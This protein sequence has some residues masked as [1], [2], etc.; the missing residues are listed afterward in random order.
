MSERA[1]LE[2]VAC[3]ARFDIGPL[4][5]GCRACGAKGKVA[6]LE[7]AYD[8]RAIGP[9][10]AVDNARGLWRW[11]SLLPPAGEASR[12]S[13]G[14]GRTP[15]L[16]IDCGQPGVRL[17]LKNE[18]ANP[19]W[20]WKD[21]PNCISVSMARQLG[22]H[23]TAAISTGNHGCAAAAYSAA[24]GMRCVVFCHSGAPASQLALM[25]SYGARVIR[26]GDQEALFRQ[27]LGRGDHFPCSIF[28]PRAGYASP[29]AIEGFKT[30]AFEIYE[31]LD[32]SIPDRVFVP[33]GS[34]DGIYGVWK[35][36]RELRELGW[37]DK[38]PKM[39]ACQASGADSA[40]RAFRKGSQHTE[41]L[42]SAST[43][44]LSIAERVTG[45]HALRAVYQSGGSV[46][47]CSD[48]ETLAAMRLLM[49]Q[50]LALEPASAV[51]LA[52]LQKVA[53]EWTPGETR[54]IIGSGAAVKWSTLTEGFE[55]PR[56]WGPDVVNIDEMLEPPRYV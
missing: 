10:L 25:S 17:L 42:D 50:G 35:G 23:R 21:R 38:T 5:Y 3:S 32:R 48:E 54:V 41:P 14:E 39:M 44:A 8:F 51:A 29:F 11:N 46:L 20:S 45:D 12:I 27:L 18:T 34:G 31:Q 43:I 28:C 30:I 33:V 40:Y 19:T 47:T 37:A 24:A 53:S 7:V 6:P 1:W 26:G 4:F 36:F 49:H 16:P 13:L 56:V 52:C 15:L 9:P 22:F 55:M 2:C